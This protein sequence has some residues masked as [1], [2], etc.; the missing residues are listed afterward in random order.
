[1]RPPV[2]QLTLLLRWQARLA[3]RGLPEGRPALLR[4]LAIAAVALP[5]ALISLAPSYREVAASVLHALHAAHGAGWLPLICGRALSVVDATVFFFG[6]VFIAQIVNSNEMRVC[7]PAPVPARTIVAAQAVWLTACLCAFVF[8]FLAPL[9]ALLALP[10]HLGWGGVIACLVIILTAAVLPLSV[11]LLLA[12]ILLRLIPASHARG[13]IA[14][15]APV[16]GCT[17]GLASRVIASLSS[18]SWLGRA[19]APVARAWE[20]SPFTWDGR[21]LAA[22]LVAHPTDVVRYAAGSLIVAAATTALAWTLAHN[23]LSAGWFA[24][25]AQASEGRDTRPGRT[26][27]VRPDVATIV[28][29]SALAL[30]RRPLSWRALLT[31]EWRVARRESA[32]R[33]RVLIGPYSMAAV[34]PGALLTAKSVGRHG[35]KALSPVLPAAL[36]AQ[37]ALVGAAI[38][39]VTV[40]FS[41]G[42]LMVALID[43]AWAREMG[44]RD[45]M[46]RAPL[47]PALVLSM[48]GLFYV[49]PCAVLAALLVA[50]GTMLLSTPVLAP[51]VVCVIIASDLVMLASVALS[52]NVAWPARDRPTGLVPQTWRARITMGLGDLAVSSVCSGFVTL[53]LLSLR[54]PLVVAILTSIPVVLAVGVI[55]LCMRTGS[56]ALDRLYTR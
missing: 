33:G 47:G 42:S 7:A 25:T 19:S 12:V 10:A 22:V 48:L 44:A 51:I 32:T 13:T 2:S 35:V 54:H 14:L 49:T 41:C 23:L 15:L 40:L 46:A 29:S 9:V 6:S 31:K 17:V 52:A 37:P 27:R 50:A 21:A 20:D 3:V 8:V 45:V 28:A 1:V 26:A 24:Y 53:A 11:A 56:R 5:I 55:A 4:S 30:A 18:A 36:H 38:Y 43:A 16:L 34:V 39:D